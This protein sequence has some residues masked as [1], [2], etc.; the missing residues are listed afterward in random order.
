MPGF[1]WAQATPRIP[2]NHVR[3]HYFRLDGNYLAWTAY[4][5]G[6]T[7][8]DTS[9]FNGR[10]VKVTEQDSFG[11]YFDVGITSA[12]QNVGIIIH[13]W[14]AVRCCP[15]PPVLDALRR[16]IEKF[17]RPRVFDVALPP[18]IQQTDPP[19]PAGRVRIHRHHPD[20]DYSVWNLFPFFATTDPNS[21]FCGGQRFRH[22]V[23]QIRRLLRCRSRS[24]AVEMAPTVHPVRRS[25][26]SGPNL[27]RASATGAN[28]F[29][30]F[31]YN[32]L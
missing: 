29:G 8:E 12:V 15:K 6:D 20:N 19:I 9:N 18:T 23:R 25:R 26:A 21:D 5:F 32:G 22:R 13:E 14:C 16:R 24:H 10:P 3:I 28:A 1:R 7:T 2:T 30:R 27:S 31:G 11:A 4:A 17:V